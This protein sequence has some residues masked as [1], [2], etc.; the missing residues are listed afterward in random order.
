MTLDEI[1][2]LNIKTCKNCGARVRRKTS[3]LCQKCDK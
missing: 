2:K 1:K 3:K